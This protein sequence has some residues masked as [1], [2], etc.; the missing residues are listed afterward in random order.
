MEEIIRGGD[1]REL[2][3]ET[4]FSLWWRKAQLRR[5]RYDMGTK[6]VPLGGALSARERER[7]GGLPA[8][9]GG[10]AREGAMRLRKPFARSPGSESATEQRHVG[11]G[12]VV[13]DNLV[14]QTKV[15]AIASFWNRTR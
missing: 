6:E 1:D 8:M 5:A 9:P 7:L 4:W 12:E 2:V 13:F 10:R 14:L 15:A 3:C 11:Q